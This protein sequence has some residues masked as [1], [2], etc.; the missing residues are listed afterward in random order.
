MSIYEKNMMIL[1]KKYSKIA[2]QIKNIEIGSLKEKIQIKYSLDGEKVL[3]VRCRERWWR[4]NSEV[5][6]ERA[7]QVYADRYAIRLYGVYFIYGFSDGKSID[8]M[9]RKGDKTNQFIIWE[10]DIEVMTVVCHHFNVADILECENVKLCVPEI[11]DRIDETIQDIID[12]T[13]MKLIEYCILPNYDVLYTKQCESFM[14]RVLD[15]IQDEL[16]KK[17]TKLGFERMIPQHMLYHMRNMISQRNIAQIKKAFEGSMPERIPAIIVSAGP[18]LDK[19]VKELKRAEGKAFIIVVDAA[20]RT[21]LRAGIHPD[22][23]CTIDPESPDRF[24]EE[25]DL[26]NII[27][28]YGKWTRPWIF[29]HYGGKIFYQGNYSTMWNASMA[30]K[31][32]YEFPELL[33]GGSV[34]ADA[35]MLAHYLGFYNI[36]LVGQD[37]AFTNGVSHTSGIEGAFGDNDDY[38]NSRYLMTVEG[39][40]GSELKTDFQMWRYK[41]WFEKIIHMNKDAFRVIDATEGGARIRGTIV[42]SL[43][44]TI[45][46]E[47]QG[48]FN[49]YD[50]INR[51][52]PALNEKQQRELLEKLMQIR[53]DVLLFSN[54]LKKTIE[55]QQKILETLKYG[56]QNDTWVMSELKDMMEQNAQIEQS[57]L[58]ELLVYYAQKEEYEIGDNIY[59]E[60]DMGVADMVEKSV[61]LLEGYLRGTELLKE[62][63]DEYALKS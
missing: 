5:S 40:D 50:I 25:L 10:P 36:V 29:E 2:D 22:V 7:S 44:D 19:N 4:L 12:Y 58:L 6:P 3:E 17:S 13:N 60:E 24:F 27:W 42:Q 55:K 51:I 11:D 15:R 30:K 35:F 20:L 16:I 54:I 62:D 23:V 28:V 8:Q 46:Q 49:A 31:L 56:Q 14:Q 39:I 61:Y 1:E 33:S 53:E 45:D 37:M 32:G 63:I 9:I 52:E 34:T 18:S 43:H 41:E 38:I 47:C 48:D 21:V 57:P 59:M 26:K